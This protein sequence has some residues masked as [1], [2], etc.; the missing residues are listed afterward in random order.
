METNVFNL[1]E[2]IQFECFQFEGSKMETN[3][4]NLNKFIQF[5]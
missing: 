4:F 1:N 3:V 2:F 5:E